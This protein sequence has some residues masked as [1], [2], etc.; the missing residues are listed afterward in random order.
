VDPIRARKLLHLLLLTSL[1]LT[2]SSCDEDDEDGGLIP[3]LIPPA[4]TSGLTLVP[5]ASGIEVS[6]LDPDDADFAE[7]VVVR[8]GGVAGG[9]RPTTGKDYAVGDSLASGVVVYAGTEGQFTDTL[10]LNPCLTNTYETWT[11]DHARNY[12]ATQES[13]SIAGEVAV[14]APSSPP[15]GLAATIA[16][17]GEVH[18]IWVNPDPA[19][20]FA[21]ARLVRK[22]GSAPTGPEDGTLLDSGKDATHID[23]VGYGS[24]PATYYYAVYACN[25]CATCEGTGDSTV[26][27]LG[28]NAQASGLAAGVNGANVDLTWTNPPPGSAFTAVRLLRKL[29]DPPAAADDPGA[30]LLYEGANAAATDSLARLLPD[31]PAFP[32]VYHYAVFSCDPLGGCGGKP[33]RTELTPT[34]SQCLAAGG[35]TIY[36][37]H[38]TA[39][40]CGDR[41]DLGTADTTKV[42]GWWRSCDPECPP[43]GNA[44]AR[45]LN[46]VTGVEEAT[47]IGTELDAKG[48]PFGEVV[49]S[50]FCRCI[51]TADHMDL[52]PAVQEVPG[53]TFF[54]YDEANRCAHCYERI[55]TLPLPGT[56]TGIIG[57]AG[58][59]DC[60]V[61]MELGMGAAA[62]FHPDGQ[63]EAE[64][65]VSVPWDGWDDLP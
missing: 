3:D 8:Y 2:I 7:T 19:S 59:N 61:V 31:T 46:P 58:F 26:V 43:E 11:T 54:V 44:T 42:D 27:T 34:V 33:A 41:M 24:E 55:R 45:Q 37:R 53:I 6:W 62:I 18:L 20:G 52:G 57:H 39:N 16:A 40:I 51:Q 13:E 23:P 56:N 22:L 25:R 5:A 29:N 35:Y 4:P 64:W 28:S 17:G 15:S 65:I 38:A 14:P 36:W 48:I 49:T 1:A 30:T 9:A 60:P 50:E 63:G 21:S 12:A 47:T 10:L 32:R